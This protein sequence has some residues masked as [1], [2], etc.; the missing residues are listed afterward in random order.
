MLLAAQS[1]FFRAK[2][3][4]ATAAADGDRL[5]LHGI[6][7]AVMPTIVKYLHTGN[8]H[9]HTDNAQALFEAAELLHLHPLRDIIAEYLD[10]VRQ[11]VEL[12][13]TEDS[14]HQRRASDAQQCPTNWTDLVRRANVR[15]YAEE[16]LPI[17]SD[18]ATAIS[19]LLLAVLL[20]VVMGRSAPNGHHDLESTAP[21]VIMVLSSRDAHLYDFEKKQWSLLERKSHDDYT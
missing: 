17:F 6:S 2:F 12:Q 4:A 19:A 9:V 11:Q 8:L 20:M 21:Q 5:T 7:A 18:G 15:Q 16:M 14:H 1:P 3:D 10:D 13:P